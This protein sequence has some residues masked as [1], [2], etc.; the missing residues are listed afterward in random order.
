MEWRRATGEAYGVRG[1]RHRFG[2]LSWMRGH[3]GAPDRIGSHSLVAVSPC[4]I[5]SGVFG[6]GEAYG[7]RGR[8][9]RFGFLFWCGGI[10]ARLTASDRIPSSRLVRVR[11]KAVSSSRCTSGLRHT[12]SIG[13]AVRPYVIP[14]SIQSPLVAVRPRS[15]QSGV[16]AAALHRH[17]AQ[18]GGLHTEAALREIR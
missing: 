3:L 9:R 12:H 1:R 6:V 15:I 8:R 14:C 11:S 17:S 10:S 5:Q 4:S 2:F 13:S 18:K 16:F 7:V